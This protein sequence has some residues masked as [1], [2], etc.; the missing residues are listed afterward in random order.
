M[1]R[2]R[3]AYENQFRGLLEGLG[4]RRLEQGVQRL[5][6]QAAS[7]ARRESL[8]FTHALVRVNEELWRK[9]RRLQRRS[10]GTR[11]DEVPPHLFL[12]DGGLGGLARWLRAAGHQ[13]VWLASVSDEE[14]LKQAAEQ[15]ATVLTTD[16][17]LLE[18]RL[19]RDGQVSLLWLPPLLRVEEQLVLVVEHFGLHGG[20]PRC[21]DCGGE[22][23]AV[24]KETVRERIPPRTYRWLDDYYLCEQCGRLFWRGSHWQNIR[25][26]LPT[27]LTEK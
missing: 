19:V 13:A 11:A 16:S 18:R 6:A 25:R 23:R 26:R 8:S 20:E 1:K 21:M 22:L 24:P 15:S 12:C 4:A 10:A 17:M 3:R 9:R 2:V 27:Q 5:F 7:L 14:L